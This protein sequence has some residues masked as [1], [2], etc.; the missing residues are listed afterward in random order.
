MVGPTSFR[1]ELLQKDTLFVGSKTMENTHGD[2]NGQWKSGE[3]GTVRYYYSFE[4]QGQV[5]YEGRHGAPVHREVRFSNPR[6]YTGQQEGHFVANGVG[7]IVDKFESGFVVKEAIIGETEEHIV[8]LEFGNIPSSPA[9]FARLRQ[10][11][12]TAI[13]ILA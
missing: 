1:L 7:L 4:E 11:G 3:A 6:E 12:T 10:V 9:D 5:T 13:V 8:T 2:G